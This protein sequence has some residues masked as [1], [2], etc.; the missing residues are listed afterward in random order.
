MS[1]DKNKS[2]QKV[3]VR[4]LQDDCMAYAVVG[5]NGETHEIDEA[6]AKRMISS[7]HAALIT[8]KTAK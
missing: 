3:K 6:L 2:D 1:E 4:L 8:D 7:G 5:K